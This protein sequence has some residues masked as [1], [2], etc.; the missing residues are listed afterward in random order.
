MR[1][2]GLWSESRLYMILET[3]QSITR[4]KERSRNGESGVEGVGGGP[5]HLKELRLVLI[6]FFIL[7]EYN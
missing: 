6:L 7:L 5:I 2:W 1:D 3:E 4:S